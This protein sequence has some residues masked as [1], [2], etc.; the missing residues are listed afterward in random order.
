MNR[1]Q[2][3]DLPVLLEQSSYLKYNL[4][5]FFYCDAKNPQIFTIFYNDRMYMM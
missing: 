3:A 2:V 5:V 1:K 4:I